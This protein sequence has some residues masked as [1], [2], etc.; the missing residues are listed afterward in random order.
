MET[1]RLKHYFFTNSDKIC[2]VKKNYILCY[3]EAANNP[4][5]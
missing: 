5:S 3:N 1:C 4:S 2:A